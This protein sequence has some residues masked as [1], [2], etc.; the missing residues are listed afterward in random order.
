MT[1]EQP[2]PQEISFTSGGEVCRGW[3]FLPQSDA[4]T[5]Y[6][7]APCVVLGHGF[8]GTR[9]AGLVPYA[10]RFAAEGFHVVIFDYR[11]FGVSDGEPRQLISIEKQ[12]QD[13]AAAA[14]FARDMQGV[15]PS[16]VAIWGSSFSGGHVIETAFLDRRVAAVIAQCPA[17]DGV[18]LLKAYLRYAG[19]ISGIRLLCAGIRD[20]VR[21]LLRW[22]PITLPVIGQPGSLAFLSSPDSEPG[23]WAIAPAGWRNEIL[24]RI[25]LEF[26]FY[27]PIRHIYELTCP[28]LQQHCLRDVIA[29]P[30]R[31]DLSRQPRGRKT[32]VVKTYDCGHFDLYQGEWFEKSLADQ[33]AFLKTVL[34]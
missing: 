19:I 4:M 33:I 1:E 34:S 10:R 3:H 29:P 6:K 21:G 25:A 28:Q 31:L 13:W 22:K 26:P 18:S 24:A 2:P 20:R 9:D 30:P 5:K 7:R 8:G 23:Y 32:I 11:H 12:L 14:A 17:L 27:R 16:R 15:D